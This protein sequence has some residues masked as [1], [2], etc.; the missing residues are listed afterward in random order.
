MKRIGLSVLTSLALLTGTVPACASTAGEDV[1]RS[2]VNAIER[3]DCP[4]AV[5]ALKDGLA[6]NLPEVVFMAGG[7]YEDGI[8]LKANWQRAVDFYVL[9]NEQGNRAA[10]YRLVSGYAAPVG[11]KDVAAAL[12]WASR[13]PGEVIGACQ[14]GAADH[15][16]PDRFVAVL[17]KW[18][19]ARLD[20]CNYVAGV[21]ATLTGDIEYPGRAQSHALNGTVVVRF[22]P[23]AAKFEIVSAET[24]ELTMSGWVDGNA[25]RD[26]QS[27]SVTGSFAKAINQIGA[28]A[29]KRYAQPAGID[30][31]WTSEVKF[32]FTLLYRN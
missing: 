3:E 10:R 24:E 31:A 28:R 30:P 21:M 23:A 15:D 20:A 26:R 13:R 2:V 11:G 19:K 18:P 12:W 1:V 27:K 4:A 8:C 16:D 5:G 17:A 7:M 25:V 14:V 29:L 6:K 9:A 32:V 22:T